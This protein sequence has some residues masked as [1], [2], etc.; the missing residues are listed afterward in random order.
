MEDQLTIA[1]V[2]ILRISRVGHERVIERV[3]TIVVASCTIDDV[4]G[5]VGVVQL[6]RIDD[7]VV[8]GG[9]AVVD[10]AMAAEV[11]VDA[12]LV[13][14]G[15][16]GFRAVRAN[17]PCGVVEWTMAEHNHPRSLAPVH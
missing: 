3:E 1:V 16:E 14:Q 7:V 12:I 8:D 4:P 11:E 5:R 9:V 17:T 13:E 15:L 10:V 6:T 2:L